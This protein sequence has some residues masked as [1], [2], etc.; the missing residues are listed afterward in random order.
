MLRTSR[1]VLTPV[2]ASDHDELLTLWRMPEVC[3][4][5]FDG[6]FLS[7]AYVTDVI[8]NS[9]KSFATANF[10]LWVVRDGVG[11][12]LFGT[13]G[14][15]ELDGGP[16]LEVVYSL[17]PA[18]WGRGLASESAAAVLD[19]GFEVLGLD[20]VLAEV[21]VGNVASRAVVEKLGMTA[22]DTVP[23]VL[24]PMIHY[25]RDRD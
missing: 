9:E 4:F 12:P 1:L 24:G 17:D 3:E 2:R 22:F 8:A 18:R 13:A 20:R 7:D 14:L 5:L 16:D 6:E 15:R 23:G 10:G 11:A 25:V 19:Y 21:D